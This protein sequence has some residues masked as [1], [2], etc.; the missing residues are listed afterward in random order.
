MVRIQ[1]IARFLNQ[2]VELKGWVVHKRSSGKIRFLNIRDGSGFIQVVLAPTADNQSLFAVFDALTQ[3]S[4]IAVTGTVVLAGKSQDTFEIQALTLEML[5]QS[6]PYPVSPKEHGVEFLMQNRHLWL[7]S[8]R[9][10]ACMR[11]RNTIIQAIHQFF[12]SEGF[13]QFDAPLLTPNSCEGTS[14]LFKTQY[15]DEM[16]F[17]SQSGQLYGEAG[18]FALGKIYTFGPTFRAEKSKTRKH[19]TE[20]WMIEPEMTFVTLDDIVTTAESLVHAI[21]KRVLENCSQEL[22]V[23]GQEPA[24]LTH[25]LKPYPKITY[26]EAL[27]ILKEKS[28]EIPWG[29]DFGSPHETAL[30]EH[31]GCPV[32]ITQFPAEIK[33]FYFLRTP[34]NQKALGCDLIAPDGYGEIIGGG[35]RE[36]RTE[37]LKE[38]IEQAGLKLDD[39]QWYLDLRR[40]GTCPHGGFGMGLERVVTWLTGSEHVRESIPFPRLLNTLRP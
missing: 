35:A 11:I 29:E 2:T 3:E 16:A 20:F 15:F 21:I 17:L 37:I 31:F 39:Y 23:C 13:I 30:G 1:E 9:Q 12:Q 36:Y 25:F 27:E 26:A 34:D 6:E 14:T 38:R 28:F 40:F 33:S 32:F 10:W 5:S 18:A 24:K 19:L 8:S 4:T 22:K 7:R